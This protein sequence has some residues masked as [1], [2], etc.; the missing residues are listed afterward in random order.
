MARSLPVAVFA[1]LRFAIIRRS[2]TSLLL[3]GVN[4]G[5]IKGKP[6]VRIFKRLHACCGNCLRL[7]ARIEL[8]RWIG[9]HKRLPI[10]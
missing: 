4:E 10:R 5:R 8:L 2:T 6:D 9:L 7:M 1:L 3:A